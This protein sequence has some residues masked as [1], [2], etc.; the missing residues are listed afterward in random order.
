[1]YTSMCNKVVQESREFFSP[2]PGKC[3]G[4][5]CRSNNEIASG[6]VGTSDSSSISIGFWQVDLEI[7]GKRLQPRDVLFPIS[8]SVFAPFFTGGY[9]K[10]GKEWML[11]S[12]RN[13]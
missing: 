6:L 3:S 13:V 2:L 12:F 11:S 9:Q 8:G 4:W 7:G 1:M 5:R 10:I